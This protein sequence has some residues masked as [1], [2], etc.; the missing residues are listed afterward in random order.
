MFDGT[1]ARTEVEPLQGKA[2]S[3]TLTLIWVDTLGEVSQALY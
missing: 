1:G 2:V 3:L